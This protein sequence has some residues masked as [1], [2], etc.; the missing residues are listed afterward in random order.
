MESILNHCQAL[1]FGGTL[2]EIGQLQ[3]Y[4]N[5]DSIGLPYSR[6]HTSLCPLVTNAKEWGAYQDEMSCLCCDTPIPGV[7]LTTRQ[8]AETYGYRVI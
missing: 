4:F 5:Q 8:P 3:R 7:L 6:M 1:A 2:G